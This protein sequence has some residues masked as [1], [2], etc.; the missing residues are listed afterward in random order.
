MKNKYDF[1]YLSDIWPLAFRDFIPAIDVLIK[2]LNSNFITY[3]P[4]LEYT[5]RCLRVTEIARRQ[6]EISIRRQA[7]LTETG[8]KLYDDSLEI[9]IKQHPFYHH[10]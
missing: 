4:E 10:S 1:R 7:Q 6:F 5:R 2:C 8:Y 3:Q 9:T